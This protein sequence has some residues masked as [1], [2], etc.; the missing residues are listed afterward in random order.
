MMLP[1]WL[2][3]VVCVPTAVYAAAFW[4]YRRHWLQLPALAK[5]PEPPRAQ[6]TTQGEKPTVSVLIAARNE[7]ANLPQ[8]LADLGRQTYL[9]EGG[10]FEVIVV[11]DHS[12]DDTA[13]VV[14]AAAARSQYP[15]RLLRLAEQSGNLTG[16]KA[17]IETAIAQAR[18]PWVL[19]TDAD[20]RVPAG[21][22]AAYAQAF[23]K[24]QL[25][26]VSG[27]VLL[28]GKGLLAALQG[29]ELAA[30]V[31][32]GA[33]SIAAGAPTMCNGANLAY[34]RSAFYAVGGFGGNAHL[35]S[36]DDEF[37]LHKI[38]AAY[39]QGIR[40]LKHPDATVRTAAQP[41]LGA[42]LQQRVRWASKW[43]H[44]QSGASRWLAVLVLAANLSLWALVGLLCWQAAVWPWVLVG[45][46]LKL[47]ADVAFLRPVL[48]FFG[49]QNW[50]KLVPLLQVMYPPYALAVGLLGLRGGYRWKGRQVAVKSAEIPRSATVEA[51][52]E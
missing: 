35:P 16:K 3:A 18:A 5:E 37:L 19:C 42:L 28:T 25:Q 48:R 21:W 29:L 23:S 51:T 20:C 27:P 39:P 7:A 9:H 36:G 52:N 49:R 26:F 34:R 13:A 4:Q 45:W 6:A 14:Q 33:A 44:Y 2:A 17:A 47:G 38:S 24:E 11:D 32:T 22:L 8:L 1:H 50:L 10:R 41:A 46:G 40:F 43:R 30:L 31:G 12:A 15:L